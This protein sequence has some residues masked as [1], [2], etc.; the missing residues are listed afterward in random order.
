MSESKKGK[1]VKKKNETKKKPGKVQDDIYIVEKLVDKREHKHGKLGTIIQYKV[2]WEGYP[3]EES[4]WEPEWNISEVMKHAYNTHGIF[5][6]VV[7]VPS[8]AD[9]I[10]NETQSQAL[11]YGAVLQTCALPACRSVECVPAEFF[12]C[13]GCVDE[14]AGVNGDAQMTEPRVVCVSE[15]GAVQ[16]VEQFT[17]YCSL[18]CQRKDWNR[19]QKQCKY[20][21][22]SK[23]KSCVPSERTQEANRKD[24][25]V[26]TA[27]ETLHVGPMANA[28][29]FGASI[30]TEVPIDAPC[31]SVESASTKRRKLDVQ[32]HS[33]V[34]FDTENSIVDVNN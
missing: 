4:T 6:Y 3:E 29:A 16:H 28:A 9:D 24:M 21:K 26:T 10:H 18:E 15:E 8:H 25:A 27:N 13:G 19:H 30:V 34:P 33:P 5:D 31:I 32:T 12:V 11:V 14:H 1:T 20:N 23:N 17:K 22:R 2:K 7:D